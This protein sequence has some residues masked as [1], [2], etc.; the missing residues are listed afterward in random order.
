MAACVQESSCDKVPASVTN[1]ASN[2]KQ[3]WKQEQLWTSHFKG[4]QYW[5][6]AS[7][8]FPHLTLWTSSTK[9]DI[10]QFMGLRNRAMRVVDYIC[11]HLRTWGQRPYAD[12]PFSNMTAS[13]RISAKNRIAAPHCL[14]LAGQYMTVSFNR[15]LSTLMLLHQCDQTH[16]SL[17]RQ[18]AGG[19]LNKN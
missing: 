4:T 2:L 10:G 3:D 15:M 12:S 16:R 18:L 8:F 9:W 14:K 17:C 1:T 6:H 13:Y 11:Y 5:I 7:S 19:R